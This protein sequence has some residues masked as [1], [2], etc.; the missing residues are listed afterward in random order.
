MSWLLQIM[1]KLLTEALDTG[2]QMSLQRTD[3]LSFR[4]TPNS[5]IEGLYGH[6]VFNF[7]RNFHTV[8]QMAVLTCIPTNSGQRI[9]FSP[10]PQ[11]PRSV[12][13]C[14]GEAHSICD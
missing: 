12:V 8:S 13:E 5:E 4:Y 11:Y 1:L 14:Q 2:V 6:S 10:H 3:F 9:F 7:L